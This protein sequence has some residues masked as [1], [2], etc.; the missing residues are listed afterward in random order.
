MRETDTAGVDGVLRARDLEH[1]LHDH[2]K[3]LGQRAITE[4]D[5]QEG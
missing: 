3:V 4:I 1:G 2:R 5:V